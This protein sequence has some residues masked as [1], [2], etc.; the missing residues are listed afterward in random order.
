MRKVILYQFY[1]SIFHVLRDTASA[2]Y[3]A[4]RM[5]IISFLINEPLDEKTNNL[6]F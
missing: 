2:V 5:V 1:T 6:G 4:K 3:V